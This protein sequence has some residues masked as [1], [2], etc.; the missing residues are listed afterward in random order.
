MV[1]SRCIAVSSLAVIL[2]ACGADKNADDL[3][4][5][6]DAVC[7][8][9]VVDAD[10][11]EQCDLGALNSDTGGCTLA[12]LQNV[13]G[14][15]LLGPDDECD[16]GDANSDSDADACRI[17]CTLA[18]CGDGVTDTGEECEVGD[19]LTNG[20]CTTACQVECTIGF[21]SCDGAVQTGCEIDLSS[22]AENCN[23]CGH[24]CGGGACNASVC[25]PVQI[26]ELSAFDSGSSSAWPVMKHH[27]GY[28]Y[29]NTE[30]GL[31][32]VATASRTLATPEIF[33]D[34]KPMAAAFTFVAD[35]VFY[36]EVQVSAGLAGIFSA[37]LATGVPSYA[38]DSGFALTLDSDATHIY[39]SWNESGTTIGVGRMA[40]GGSSLEQLGSFT[41]GSP[42]GATAIFVDAEHVYLGFI[43]G[44]PMWRVGKTTATFESTP[45]GTNVEAWAVVADS[46]NL[47]WAGATQTAIY[48]ILR[49]PYA[50][51]PDPFCAEE[52]FATTSGRPFGLAIDATDVYWVELDSN[53]VARRPRAGGI[54]QI[55]ATGL[56]APRSI[57]VD[58]DFIYWLDAPTDGS[59]ASVWKLAK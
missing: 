36:Y 39:L 19:V 52:S 1:S 22:S 38:A 32:R 42:M 45:I 54:T 40:A 37:P 16:D 13:C 12:C 56:V 27:L 11:G 44:S 2:M 43:S 29:I 17:D 35:E 55:V 25:S 3:V 46:D 57:A 53:V 10:L 18:T 26:A 21:G 31:V 23:A 51:L 15:G 20:L 4:G 58:D 24:D 8:D 6:P 41:S 49:E 47:Y 34:I 28:V 33:S 7:G 9:A 30:W 48:R 14:D 5:R 59:V 50:C